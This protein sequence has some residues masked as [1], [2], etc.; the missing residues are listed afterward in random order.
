M[1]EDGRP[2]EVANVIWCTG[3]HPGFSWIELDIFDELG[4]PRQLGGVVTDVPGLYFVGLV[5][6]YSVS[7]EMIHGVGRDAQR[8]AGIV[9]KRVAEKRQLAAA[10]EARV[11]SASAG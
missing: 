8:I 7:S 3:F 6:V 1:L 10:S 4:H 5:F 11:L 9:S 2:L